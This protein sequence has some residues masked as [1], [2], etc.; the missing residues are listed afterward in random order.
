M[1]V[2]EIALLSLKYILFVFDV[3]MSIMSLF[4]KS[5]PPKKPHGSISEFILPFSFNY[6]NV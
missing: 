6:K 2:Y 5:S 4:R 1:H 3:I